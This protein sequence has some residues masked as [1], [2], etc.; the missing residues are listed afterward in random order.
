[1]AK[2]PRKAA[3]KMAKGR[4]QVILASKPGARGQTGSEDNQINKMGGGRLTDRGIK[5]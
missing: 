1:M 4:S 3:R 2:K 5:R